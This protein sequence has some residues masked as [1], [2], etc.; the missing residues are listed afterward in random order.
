MNI[1]EAASPEVLIGIAG[2]VIVLR[3]RQTQPRNALASFGRGIAH[4]DNRT[5]RDQCD[6]DI[7][8]RLKRLV[9]ESGRL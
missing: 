6:H 1:R 8:D 7:G 4:I 3:R 2:D 9:I 5:G